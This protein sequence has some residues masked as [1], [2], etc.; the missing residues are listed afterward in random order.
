VRILVLTIAALAL[1][2][3]GGD[4]GSAASPD[5]VADCLENDGA[6]VERNISDLDYIAQD[7]GVGALGAEV[8]GNTATLVFERS[9]SDASA[10]AQAYEMFGASELDQRGSLLV[11][12]DKTPT[13]AEKETLGAC[14]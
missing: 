12:W 3:C 6:S 7:A 4:S 14:L 13:D 1:V 2:G 11:V 5:S 8:G 9:D 10:T